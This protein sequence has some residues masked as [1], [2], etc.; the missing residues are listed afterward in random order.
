MRN[1]SL[2]VPHAR[3][4]DGGTLNLRQA[5]APA[6]GFAGSAATSL[7]SLAHFSAGERKM[8][9]RVLV[10]VATAGFVHTKLMPGHSI[11]MDDACCFGPNLAQVGGDNAQPSLRCNS[12]LPCGLDRAGISYQT[13]FH[14]KKFTSLGWTVISFWARPFL[15][16]GPWRS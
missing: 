6:K 2:R 12:Y 11:K 16:S 15:A 1:G 3:P 5:R 4:L 14:F 10:V 7:D 13:A 8:R 9:I